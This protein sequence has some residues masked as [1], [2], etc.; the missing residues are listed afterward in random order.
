MKRTLTILLVLAMLIGLLPSAI[1]PARAEDTI[2]EGYTPIYD[3]FDLYFV[4]NDLTANYILMA[5]LDLTP[6]LAEGGDLY[7]AEGW[8]ALGYS[9]ASGSCVQFTGTFDGNGHK[10]SGLT[11]N[12]PGAGLLWQIGE[13][14]TVKNLTIASGSIILTHGSSSDTVDYAGSIAQRN[15][16]LI[17]N[18][19]N[20]ADVSADVNVKG[21]NLY[22][23]GITGSNESAS[24]ILNS[25]NYGTVHGINRYPSFGT[26][27][28]PC[29]TVSSGGITGENYGTL[30]IVWNR[31]NIT[32]ESVDGYGTY[33][34]DKGSKA[35][36]IA[37]YVRSGVVI[38]AYNTGLINA[39]NT[40]SG[41][42][43]AFAG[44]IIGVTNASSATISCCYNVGQISAVSTDTSYCG[45]ICGRSNYSNFFSYCYYLNTIEQGIGNNATN[46]CV[47]LSDALMRKQQSFVGFDFDGIW[48]MGTGDYLYPILTH[49][50]VMTHVDAVEPTCTT[51]GS[52]EYWFCA[53]CNRYFADENGN[54]EITLEETVVPGGHIY[55][56]VIVA[57]T[58]T[59]NGYTKHVCSRCGNY[60]IDTYTPALGHDLV[61]DQGVEPTCT[62]PGLTGGTHCSRCDYVVSGAEEIP[63]LGHNWGNWTETAAPTCTASGTETRTCARCGENETRT[64]NALGHDYH[65]TVTPPTCTEQ[66]F[67]THTCSRCGDSYVDSYVAAL[68]HSWDAGTLIKEPAEGENGLRRYTCTRCGETRDEVVPALDHVH[69]YTAVVTAPTCTEQGFTTYTCTCGDSYVADYV[70][71]LG[72][73]FGAWSQSKAPTCTEPGEEART[74]SRC[75]ATETRPVDA[76]G[77]EWNAPVYSWS[78]DNSTVTATRTCRHDASHVETETVNSNRTVAVEPTAQTDGQAVYTA[79]FANPAFAA[80]VKVVPIPKLEQPD[81]PTKPGLP[82]TGDETCPGLAQFTDMPARGNWAHNPIDWAV[83]NEIT[84]GM[85]ATTF[86]PAGTIT[87]GQAVTFLWRA[88]GKPAPEKT[89]TPFTDLV[90]GAFYY[91]AVLWAVEKG[92]TNGMTATTFNPGGS[93]TRGQIVT[94]LY[95]FAG[96]PEV[97][98]S[99]SPFTDLKDGAFYIAPVAWAVANNITNGMS[100]TTF[101]PDATC[102][103]AQVVTFLYRQQTK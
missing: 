20:Y 95:R 9:P 43:N 92:I 8:L 58:C 69:S 44:G 90:E 46:S 66:G 93:C 18:C 103:R 14:G 19:H 13:T 49:T 81:E 73:S 88:A 77:H 27:N 47:S 4:K 28:N 55:E 35:G 100:A 82:C 79:A 15:Y 36:G 26:S 83:V 71:A 84:N 98:T 21:L 16:G 89:E 61:T 64:I 94:F 7:N 40:S 102:T 63:A 3:E 56:D 75:D 45:G 50:H 87:R 17:E 57:P 99:N 67:T 74:C 32:G 33:A 86:V 34:V 12:G 85:T 72:H 30:N 31:G 59:A 54:Q 80:Q 65:D 62:E 70:P 11:C 76:L 41:G 23:G 24:S 60:Y 101:A 42:N 38:N 37:G 25:S 68:G 10:I 22:L 6:Y 29:Y 97:D 91:D 51:D 96:S 48:S 52:I 53:K 2:P 5:D 1:L 39:T 78:A